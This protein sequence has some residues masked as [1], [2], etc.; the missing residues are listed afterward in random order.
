MNKLFWL[1]LVFA[2][3]SLALE[4]SGLI[5]VVDADTLAIG[6]NRIRLHGVDPR[7]SA[8]SAKQ[9]KVALTDAVRPLWIR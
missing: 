4:V 9:S 6:D 7:K 5:R 1:I 2:P 3:V 8:R